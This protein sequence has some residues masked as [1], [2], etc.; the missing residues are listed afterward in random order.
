[1][2]VEVVPVGALGVGL[3]LVDVCPFL[4]MSR[5]GSVEILDSN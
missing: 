1:M 4:R 5:A 2:N 3:G